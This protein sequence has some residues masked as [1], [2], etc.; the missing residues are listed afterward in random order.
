M[1]SLIDKILEN[2]WSVSSGLGWSVCSGNQPKY[3][4]SNGGQ[5]GPDLGGQFDRILQYISC[6]LIRK[7]NSI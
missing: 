4:R 7:E 3:S 6:I 5:F 2:G 1:L